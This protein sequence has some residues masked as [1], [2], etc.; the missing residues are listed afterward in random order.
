MKMKKRFLSVLLSFVLVL[1]LMPGM[2]LTAYADGSVTEVSTADGF[3]NAVESGGNVKLTDNIV[4]PLNNVLLFRKEM[5]IDLN[6]HTITVNKTGNYCYFGTNAPVTI[7]DGAGGGRIIN[8]S[9]SRAILTFDNGS[10]TLEGGMLEFTGSRNGGIDV[11]RAP[12]TM[13][14]GTIKSI[15]NSI[16]SDEAKVTISGG[17]LIGNIRVTNGE[18]DITGGSFSF[19]PSA[20]LKEGY[21]A[22]KVGDYWEVNAAV[23]Y[24]VTLSGGANATTSGGAT[25]Q[26]GISGEMETVTYTAKSGYKFPETSDYFK[27]TNGITVARTSDTVV[28]VSGTPTADIEMTVPDAEEVPVHRHNIKLIERKEPTYTENGYKEHYEC[29]E[30][31][32]WFADISGSYEY[33]DEERQKLIIPKLERQEESNS[34]SDSDSDSGS[35]SGGGSR[36]KSGSVSKQILDVNGNTVAGSSGNLQPDSGM[37]VSDRGG[38]WG[39]AANIWSYIKSDGALAR[40]EWLNLE[41]NGHTYWYYFNDGALM[42][43]DWLNLNGA[44]YYFVPEGDGW[45]GRMATGWKNIDNKWYYFEVIPGVSQGRLYRSSV[46]PDGHTVGADGVWNGV[47]A[48]PVGQE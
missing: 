36:G 5:T 7:R 15:G 30:C 9:E 20:L 46:T 38:S 29:T 23:Y 21:T 37:P 32:K 28:T 3:K 48:T 39:G 45:R 10:V 25:N 12:F 19:D 43:T 8:P 35:T 11:Y 4:L 24:N 14:G 34:T 42:Q 47:G 41:Y 31:G 6:G 26:T 33:S 22:S 2:G 1:G 17:T 27:T 18:I 44:T 13:T 16:W 40:N